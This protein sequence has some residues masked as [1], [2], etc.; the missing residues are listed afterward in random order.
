MLNTVA[1]GTSRGRFVFYLVGS[2]CGWKLY[3]LFLFH[4][5][6]VIAIDQTQ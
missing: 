1:R 3:D 5:R 4:M 2:V 6:V